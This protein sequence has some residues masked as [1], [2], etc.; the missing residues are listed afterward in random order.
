MKFKI[1]FKKK[2]ITRSAGGDLFIFSIML[3]GAAIYALPLIFLISSAFKPMNELWIY[4]P[5]FFVRN[6]TIKNFVDLFVLMGDSWVPITRYFF[7]TVFLVVVGTGGNIILASMGAYPL[8]KHKFFFKPLMFQTIILSL[9]FTPAVTAIPNYLTMA[10]IGWVDN[11]MALIVPAWAM[12]LGIFLMRQFMVAMVPDELL[13]A[14]QVD[15]AKEWTIFWKIVM[16]IVKPAWL[17]L[18]ILSVQQLWME[19][20]SRFIYTEQL[21]TLPYALNQIY[22]SGLARQGV[23]FAGAL[24]MASVPIII[25]VINQSKVVETMG[26]SGID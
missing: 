23:A 1:Q 4:P 20:G 12:S 16:P 18:M 17:T 25:F 8:A 3:I 14:A 7:N 9:M 22:W 13:E 19:F 24:L 10:K 5:Q 11:Y 21:K 15:G 6:P 26:T 2:R